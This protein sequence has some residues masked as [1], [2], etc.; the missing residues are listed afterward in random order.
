M[1]ERALIIVHDNYQED[2]Y[3]PLGAAYVA[4]VFDFADVHV[5]TYCMDVYHHTN[6]DLS[7]YLDCHDY[8]YI[9]LGYLAAR[10]NET[11]LDLSRV[12]NEKKKDAKFIIGGHG[13]TPIPKYM[14]EK[15]HADVAIL[16]EAEQQ[17]YTL[18]QHVPY[19]EI[20]GIAFVTERNE[21]EINTP[22]K[23]IKKVGLIPFPLWSVFPMAKYINAAKWKGWETGDRSFAIL[24]SRGCVNKCNFCYRMEKG[25]RVRSIPNIIAEIKELN[26][27]YGINYFL[28]QDECFILNKKRLQLF[29]DA[30][31][32]LNFPIKYCCDCIVNRFDDE[33]A[34]MLKES[35][36]QFINFGFESNNQKILDAIHKRT[37][38]AQNRKAAEIAMKHEL[39]MGLNFIWNE[40]GDDYETICNNMEFIKEFSDCYQLRTVKPVT[41]YPGSELYYRALNDGKLK[42]EDDFFR[43]YKNTDLITV[44][45]MDIDR[46]EAHR[47][48]FE[49]NSELIRWH[50][51]QTNR[52]ADAVDVDIE[53]FRRLYFE[54]DYH[55]RGVRHYDK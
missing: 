34:N 26:S 35:G 54:N 55:F 36:C 12:I 24:T 33:I 38:I 5:D 48:L 17:I 28:I 42:D 19:G 13:V 37:T 4:A 10:F 30:L 18:T 21:I 53:S 9:C 25:I 51:K 31:N 50:G 7:D 52:D 45:Y 22:A 1:N 16:G 46:D 3:F 44:N 2:N 32:E 43:K 11:V 6:D 14:L 23:P 41:P 20:D 15:T 47:H 40:Y 27:T 49:I 39:A 8:D 29:I